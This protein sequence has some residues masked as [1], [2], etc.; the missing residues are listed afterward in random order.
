M[1]C[2]DRFLAMP[3]LAIKK[4]L[5]LAHLNPSFHP[6]GSFELSLLSHWPVQILP[7]WLLDS[8]FPWALARNTN[9]SSETKS[10]IAL[11]PVDILA[12]SNWISLL[13]HSAFCWSTS[14]RPPSP[15]PSQWSETNGI[16]TLMTAPSIITRV[17]CIMAPRPLQGMICSRHFQMSAS[18]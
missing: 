16:G 2:I 4:Q 18:S 15:E 14:L 12:L 1:R 6:I 17:I 3:L 5:W 13:T 11:V 10:Y 8:F 9:H 7:L